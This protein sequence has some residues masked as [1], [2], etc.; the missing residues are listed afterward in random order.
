MDDIV[1]DFLIE[2]RE[3]L[4]RLDQELVSLESDPKSKDLLASIFR[5]IHTI[6]GS[7]GFLGFSRGS[8]RSART[9]ESLALEVAGW[10]ALAERRHYERIAGDGRRSAPNAERN[11]IDP[12]PTE[13]NDYAE[14]LERLKRSAIM[15]RRSKPRWPPKTKKPRHCR[16]F[17]LPKIRNK[18]RSV[19]ILEVPAAPVETVSS[20]PK[21]QPESFVSAGDGRNRKKAR[22]GSIPSGCGEEW[23][24]AGGMG[25]AWRPGT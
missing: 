1:K 21:N 12:S 23:G 7:C 10:S 4:D 25:V 20:P 16:S 11:P 8:N 3:N 5:T 15:T 6:K 14:L 19:R 24:A 2:S 22:R 18:L 17:R 13:R 9:G